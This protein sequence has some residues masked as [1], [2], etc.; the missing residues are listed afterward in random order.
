MKAGELVNFVAPQVGGKGGGRPD[1]AQAGGTNAAALAGS[2]RIRAGLGGRAALTG[3]RR[4]PSSISTEPYAYCPRCA[5]PLGEREIA[6]VDG[7]VT[8]RRACTEECGFVQWGNPTPAVGALVEHE[9]EIILARNRSWPEGC[10]ALVTGYLEAQ[11]DP[12]AAVVREVR[13]E[14]GL[15]VV[16][17]HLI[18]NYIFERKN[19]IMLCYHV[20]ARGTVRLGEE[21][22]EYRR[23][24][25]ASLRPWRRATG[26]AVADWMRARGLAFEWDDRPAAP[27]RVRPAHMSA[28]P[29]NAS[30]PTCACAGLESLSRAARPTSSA[31]S[32]T[33]SRRWP[34]R[35]PLGDP[36]SLY[37]YPVPMLTEDGTCSVVDEMAPVPY[38]LARDPRRAQRA[39]HAAPGAARAARRARAGDHGRRLGR[40]STRRARI[41]PARPC[42]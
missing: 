27:T 13:E 29:P 38:D 21:L 42:W 7:V 8:T 25:P 5:R 19:E 23:Y 20:V 9:G 31:R 14:L 39:D 17:A 40:A 22:A 6:D 34:R 28:A 41:P 18:G 1:M 35:S 12:R 24:K 26:L 33:S 37:A 16:E 10:F 4:G 15:E 30:P 36:A 32:A 3:A 2:A 11:E